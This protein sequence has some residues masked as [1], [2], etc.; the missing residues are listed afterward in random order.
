[1]KKKL[2]VHYEIETEDFKG[3]MNE[4]GMNLEEAVDQQL[5]DNELEL[6]ELPITHYEIEKER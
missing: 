3:L 4:Y 1:M 2:I 5:S 6:N